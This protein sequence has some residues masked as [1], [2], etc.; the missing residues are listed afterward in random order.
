MKIEDF[1]IGDIIT[2]K[3]GNK[4]I[5]SKETDIKMI[6]NWGTLHEIIKVERYVQ[7]ENAIVSTNNKIFFN[8]NKCYILE[9][10]YKRKDKIKEIRKLV[11]EYEDIIDPDYGHKDMDLVIKIFTKM[12]DIIEEFD[13][14][15]S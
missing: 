4:L 12:L 9:T 3:C 13:S 6:E 10:I 2:Y 11:E 7:Q 5:L 15:K 14:Q 8:T 1:K